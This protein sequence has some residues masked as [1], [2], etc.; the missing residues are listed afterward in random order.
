MAITHMDAR[1][2]PE[3]RAELA[4]MADLGDALGDPEWRAVAEWKNGLADVMDGDVQGGLGRVGA[5]AH[6][7]EIAGW[8]AFYVNDDNP[9]VPWREREVEAKRL[10]DPP[11]V[12]IKPLPPAVI[13]P[14]DPP[15]LSLPARPAGGGDAPRVLGFQTRGGAA[16][17]AVVQM[18]GE[19]RAQMMK[20]GESIGRWTFVGIEAGNIANFT[21]GDGR[22]YAI[23]IGG[24]R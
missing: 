8:E 10:K 19:T 5:V 9:F 11:K 12:V 3:A 1:A 6:A 7:A 15:K 2:L 23:V 20:P 18:P 17:S 22:K 13:K 4:R 16:V 14:I 21:D 24:G